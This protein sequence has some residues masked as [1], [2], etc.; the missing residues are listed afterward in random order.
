MTRN[1]DLFY[2]IADRIER[3]PDD[4]DQAKWGEDN[5]LV[6]AT[7]L[8]PSDPAIHE[9]V[10]D[11]INEC[12]TSHCIA[13]HAADLEGW[14]PSMYVNSVGIHGSWD[15]VVAPGHDPIDRDGTSIFGVARDLLGL[16]DD[17]ASILFSE[18]WMAEGWEPEMSDDQYI[19]LVA[20][21]LRSFGDGASIHEVTADN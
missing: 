11:T 12:G 9:L 15:R 13:G 20:K 10:A 4:Y 7:R 5:S 3:Q 17:E 19:P 6:V 18:Y 2:K 21:A 16:T 8:D 1:R 14:V